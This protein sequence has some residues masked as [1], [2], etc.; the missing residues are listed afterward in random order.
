VLGCGILSRD[1]RRWR[2]YFTGALV[3]GPDAANSP[4]SD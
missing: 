1:A 2:S 4:S 3:I